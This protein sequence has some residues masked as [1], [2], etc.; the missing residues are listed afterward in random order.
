VPLRRPREVADIDAAAVTATGAAIRAALEIP[1]TN[2][3]AAAE[4]DRDEEAAEP[5]RTPAWS[6]PFGREGRP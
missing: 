1:A 4:H 6:D 3:R 2:R 5:P